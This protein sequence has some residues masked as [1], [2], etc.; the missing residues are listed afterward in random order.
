MRTQQKV[1][2]KKD[3]FNKKEGILLSDNR[4]DEMMANVLEMYP[5]QTTFMFLNTDGQVKKSMF[6]KEVRKYFDKLQGLDN[7][8]ANGRR[9]KDKKGLKK[10]G[11]TIM[12]ASLSIPRGSALILFRLNFR[13]IAKRFSL[14]NDSTKKKVFDKWERLGGRVSKLED[15]INDGKNKKMLVCGKKCRA[16]A[17]KNPPI[18]QDIAQ[19]FVNVAGG[20]DVVYAGVIASGIGVV[21]TLTGVIGSGVNSRKNYENQVALMELESEL[22][23]RENQENAIDSTMTPSEKKIAEEIIKAQKKNADPKEAIKNNVNLTAEEK[24]EALKQLNE[25]EKSNI[26][27]DTNKKIIFGALLLGALAFFGYKMYKGKTQE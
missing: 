3:N 23:Q 14:L 20:D 22:K 1:K 9:N 16:K 17:G 5:N 26:G 15:A 8:S 19:N 7:F 21:S 27:I 24:E 25:A 6:K 4:Q 2:S 13:G 12:T 11:K 10:V 18:P